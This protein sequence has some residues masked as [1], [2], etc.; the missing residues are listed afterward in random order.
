MSDIFW[1]L[2]AGEPFEWPVSAD[3][4]A[5]WMSVPCCVDNL[6]HAASLDSAAVAARRDYTLPVL[7]PRIADLVDALARRF[8]DDRRALVS[9]RPNAQ[10][11][12]AFGCYPSLDARAAERIGFRH[13]GDIENLVANAL[14]RA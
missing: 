9:Y 8:G 12:Q 2:S 5:W 11:E 14:W 10:L 13:D 1:R 4:V 7:R 3:A 6:L